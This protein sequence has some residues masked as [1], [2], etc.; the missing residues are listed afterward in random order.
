M[1]HLWKLAAVLFA[2]TLSG[3]DKRQSATET[4]ASGPTPVVE[5]PPEAPAPPPPP[6]DGSAGTGEGGDS[7][8]AQGD[9]R[10]R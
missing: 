6:T 7:G 4:P 3:C 9:S 2:L 1:N 5:Q 8:G 10:P